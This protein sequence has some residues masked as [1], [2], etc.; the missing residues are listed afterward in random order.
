MNLVI[1]NPW[2]YKK[3]ASGCLNHYE[4]I[5]TAIRDTAEQTDRQTRENHGGPGPAGSKLCILSG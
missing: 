4:N 2:I 1:F 5:I 3:N